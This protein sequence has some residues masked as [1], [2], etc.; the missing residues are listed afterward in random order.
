M[1][2]KDYYAILEVNRSASQEEIKAAYRKLVLKYHPDRNKEDL[3]AEEKL[4]DVNEAFRVLSDINKRRQYDYFLKRHPQKVY[5]QKKAAQRPE[6]ETIPNR[7]SKFF[8]KVFNQ[9]SRKEVKQKTKNSQSEEA[10]SHTKSTSPTSKNSAPPKLKKTIEY[11]VTVTLKE[12]F[13]GTERTLQI[14]GKGIAVTIP[15]GVKT[16]THVKVSLNKK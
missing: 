6:G 1:E 2:Y 11:P 14:G 5:Q 12:A 8:N 4:K 10:P 15:R 7:F 13:E 9:E 3:Q 16:G